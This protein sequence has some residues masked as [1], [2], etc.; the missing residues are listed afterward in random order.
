M[1]SVR[2]RSTSLVVSLGVIHAFVV[3]LLLHRRQA[4]LG[5]GVEAAYVEPMAHWLRDSLLYAP[6]G[7][8]LLLLTTL[9]A[10]RV[11]TRWAKGDDGLVPA[12]VWAG[13]GAIAYALI[14]VPAAMTHGALFGV[15]HHAAPSLLQ[16]SYEGIV[17]LRYSFAILLAFAM[18]VGLPWAPRWRL[19]TGGSRPPVPTSVHEGTERC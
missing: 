1:T 10:H 9:A 5:H 6:V 18:V 14:S 3:V 15:G 13:L 12:L 8:L 2:R 16:A 4:D 11:T 17:T 19:R 7:V